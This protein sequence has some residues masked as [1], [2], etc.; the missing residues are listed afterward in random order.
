MKLKELIAISLFIPLAS[1][2]TVAAAKKTGVKT[3]KAIECTTLLCIQTQQTAEKIDEK[4]LADGMTQY[5]FRM[6][7][8]QGS[9]LRSI[10]Y[11]SL[12]VLSLGISELATTPL[13][14][15]LQN[16][17]QFAVIM[18]CDSDGNC[19]RMVLYEHEKPAVIVR[20]H[21]AEELAATNPDTDTN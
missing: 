8:R 18:D 6:Q 15:A 11:G 17:E 20:G 16:D 5:T 3:K 2:S 1:C 19:P 14:G 7:K 10:G 21:T 9:Y 12:A 4:Q 13:E